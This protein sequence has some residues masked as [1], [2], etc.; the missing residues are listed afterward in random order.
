M[1]TVVGGEAPTS[2][3]LVAWRNGGRTSI[4]GPRGSRS[5][6]ELVDGA[7]HGLDVERATQAVADLLD[8]LGVDRSEGTL[9]TPGR[10]A[11]AFAELLTPKPF[12]PTTFANE[13]GYDE[14]V[15]ARAIPFASICEHH[16]LPFSGVAHVGYLPG[17]R[18]I[19][20]SK[21]ARIV[22]HFSRRL[23]VQ[24]RL[25][26]QVAGWLTQNLKARGVGVVLEA[27]HSC[28]SLR[29]VRASGSRT[30]TSAFHG[31]LRTDERT[32]AEFFV[33][34]RSGS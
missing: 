26:S 12:A 1:S 33:L 2:G 29:G 16:L 23:Q 34:V 11:R 18:L 28:M 24:E 6:E 9:E 13:Q 19:G 22:D 14:L 10:V 32:R 17:A 4:D 5:D 8:A 30:F 21:L 25:T 31:L 27:E 20:L 3:P 15:L 7:R